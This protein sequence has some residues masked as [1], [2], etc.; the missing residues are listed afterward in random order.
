MSTIDLANL[1]PTISVAEFAE[2]F[3]VSYWTV[4]R[5]VKT[6]TCPV[7]PLRLGRSL[8]FPTAH[9]LNVL[10]TQNHEDTL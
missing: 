10:G 9:V 4:L 3:G 7:Q 6:G 2:L 5:A 8:R 1:P